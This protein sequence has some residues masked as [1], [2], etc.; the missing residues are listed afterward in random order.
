MDD[1]FLDAWKVYLVRDTC[2]ASGRERWKR[3]DVVYLGLVPDPT[4]VVLHVKQVKNRR[5]GDVFKPWKW[6]TTVS[7]NE[8]MY[9]DDDVEIPALRGGHWLHA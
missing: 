5:C 8:T 9:D 2:I 3:V 7:G 1:S 6:F 4:Y